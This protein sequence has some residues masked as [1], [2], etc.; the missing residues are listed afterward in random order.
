MIMSPRILLAPAVTLACTGIV[1]ADSVSLTYISSFG[2]QIQATLD[3]NT[4]TVRAGLMTWTDSSSDTLY[5]FCTQLQEGVAANE[6]YSFDLV[7]LEQVPDAPTSPTP[8]GS[9]RA[10]LVKDL[11]ARYYDTSG[12]DSHQTAFNMVIWEITHEASMGTTA[13]EIL[14][15]LDISTGT[16]QFAGGTGANMMAAMMLSNLGSGGGFQSY[17]LI[18]ATNPDHQDIIL[19][20]MTVVP[21]PAGLVALCGLAGLRRR[22]R[23]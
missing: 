10:T 19:E 21:G 11:Y 8:M 9:A 15:D 18:G 3:G 2:S 20:N 4:S 23:G 6:T 1:S 5:A 14:A 13:T 7:A 17:D 16:A 12:T 22:R